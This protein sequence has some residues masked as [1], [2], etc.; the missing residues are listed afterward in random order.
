MEKRLPYTNIHG[1]LRH[2]SRLIFEE[3]YS[4]AAKFVESR[5]RLFERSKARVPA[6]QIQILRTTLEMAWKQIQLEKNSNSDALTG[7]ANRRYFDNELSRAMARASRSGGRVALALLDIDHFK[8]FNDTYGH[9]VGDAVLKGVA[10]R[11]QNIVQR[12][13]DTAVRYGG[14]EFAVIIELGKKDS[15]ESILERLA[16]E[17]CEEFPIEHKGETYNLTTSIG[18]AFSEPESTP[19]T[20]IS[21]ADA[22][23]Y[24]AKEAGRARMEVDMPQERGTAPR[25]ACTPTG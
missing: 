11:L 7:L 17:M 23:L 24:A 10:K 4:E 13:S 6:A 14:E 8:R 19:Q 2:C 5:L 9:Q 18:V 22:V 3:K 25:P 1:S 12:K 20:L 15:P 16:T 21:K